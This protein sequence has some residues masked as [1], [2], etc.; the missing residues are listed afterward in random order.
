[1]IG[2]AEQLKDFFNGKKEKSAQS[3]PASL[4]FRK[5]EK[6]MG[7]EGLPFD[8]F[9]SESHKLSFKVSDHPLQDGSTI[10]DHVH[11]ELQE[12]TIEGLFTNYT[13]NNERRNEPLK[14]RDD[15]GEVDEPTEDVWTK[16]PIVQNRAL[17]QLEKLRELANAR[18]P[19]RLV[20]SLDIYP[21]M[22][23][24]DIAYDRDAKSGS[25]VKFSVTLREIVTVNL[26]TA[27]SS[28]GNTKEQMDSANARMTAAKV[29]SGKRIGDVIDA[30]E[31]AKLLNVEVLQ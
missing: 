15:Y 11:R 31:L 6:N 24:T 5:S 20:C 25:A 9:I 16:K 1:M 4:F 23:I 2:Y 12:V 10:S 7:I 18:E 14:F 8:L 26:A 13:L 30:D 3:I 22:I 28:Y 17:K 29:S 21:K 27:V 19:V